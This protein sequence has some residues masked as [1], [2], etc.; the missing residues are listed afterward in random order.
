MLLLLSLGQV[1]ESCVCFYI[2]GQVYDLILWTLRRKQQACNNYSHPLKV[3]THF[4]MGSLLSNPHSPWNSE[5]SPVSVFNLWS[6]VCALVL[7]LNLDSTVGS[8]VS[9]HRFL[10]KHKQFLTVCILVD[11]LC[12]HFLLLSSQSKP[13]RQGRN[14]LDALVIVSSYVRTHLGE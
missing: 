8:S 9:T 4:E 7:G 10:L 13:P 6:H 1:W 12:L 11:F 3:Q 14:M 2:S 5:C